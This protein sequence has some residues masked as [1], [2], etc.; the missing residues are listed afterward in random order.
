MSILK[1]KI[2]YVF[3]YSVRNQAWLCG[4]CYTSIFY[5]FPFKCVEWTQ[6]YSWFPNMAK[7][8]SCF[9]YSEET[10]V[11]QV[12][13]VKV[14]M[15]FC[16]HMYRLHC[17]VAEDFSIDLLPPLCYLNLQCFLLSFTSSRDVSTPKHN[18]GMEQ[19][20][21]LGAECKCRIDLEC[22]FFSFL[23]FLWCNHQLI[24]LGFCHHHSPVFFKVQA[25]DHLHQSL[26]DSGRNRH[27]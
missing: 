11:L 13:L 15:V 2:Y 21:Y 6:S 16:L 10:S 19:K 4:P 17:L 3:F 23:P 18:S 8:K 24:K 1:S 27:S 26:L 14:V 25:K 12:P 7:W 22:G 9:L 5:I 20:Y